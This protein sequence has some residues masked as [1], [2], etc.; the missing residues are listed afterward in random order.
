[1]A[2]LIFSLRVDRL[3]C[4]IHSDWP[5]RPSLTLHIFFE[6]SFDYHT[7]TSWLWIPPASCMSF[8]SEGRDYILDSVPWPQRL[9]QTP[10]L[11]L[12]LRIWTHIQP[13]SC[14]DLLWPVTVLMVIL[15]SQSNR[16]NLLDS[17]SSCDVLVLQHLIEQDDEE[18]LSGKWWFILGPNGSFLWELNGRKICV[19]KKKKAVCPVTPSSLDSSLCPRSRDGCVT[20]PIS[21]LLAI[22][23]GGSEKEAQRRDP[24]IKYR[25]RM[26]LCPL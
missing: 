22:E 21:Y 19:K 16:T 18:C 24:T 26:W 3:D 23:K 4:A 11:M 9:S 10:L 15:V 8:H 25:S 2:I 1:M 7:C 17:F 6:V 14:S 12:E 20:D 13:L 5:L